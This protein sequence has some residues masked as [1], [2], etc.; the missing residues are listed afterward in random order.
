[1]SKEEHETRKSDDGNM[2]L[3][4]PTTQEVHVEATPL[5]DRASR[6]QGSEQ[7]VQTQSLTRTLIIEKLHEDIMTIE[8]FIDHITLPVSAPFV[9]IA[10]KLIRVSDS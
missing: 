2:V 1:M 7:V 8:Q 9:A 4:S 3:T 5:L 6:L 10:T